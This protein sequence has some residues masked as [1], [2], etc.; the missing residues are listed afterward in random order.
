MFDTFVDYR[1]KASHEGSK[2]RIKRGRNLPREI[3]DDKALGA[4]CASGAL[5]FF[6]AEIQFGNLQTDRQ[7]GRQAGR[8]DTGNLSLVRYFAVRSALARSLATQR[9]RIY[10]YIYTACAHLLNCFPIIERRRDLCGIPTCLSVRA[11]NTGLR[12]NEYNLVRCPERLRV[13]RVS[14]R[15]LTIAC[16]SRRDKIREAFISAELANSMSTV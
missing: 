11:A 1:S 8:H 9:T 10:V 4:L 12:L 6:L 16:L 5:R 7:A 13:E 14:D 2:N 15:R 3:T